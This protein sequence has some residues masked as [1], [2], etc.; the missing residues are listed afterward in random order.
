[1]SISPTSLVPALRPLHVQA[2]GAWIV[3]AAV[4]LG[5][6]SAV[7][8]PGT[9]RDFALD[10]SEWNGLQEL[11][12]LASEQG[13]RLERGDTLDYDA[14]DPSSPLIL[15]HPTQPLD[16]SSLQDF[17]A[18]GGRVLIADDFGSSETLLTE[19]SEPIQRVGEIPEEAA[20]DHL[21]ANPNLPVLVTPGRHAL[22]ENDVEILIANHP[23]G[24]LSAL[25]AVVY[26]ADGELGFVYD[27]TIGDGKLLVVGDSSIFINL[28]LPLADNRQFASNALGYLCESSTSPCTVSVFVGEF[29][30]SGTYGDET[31]TRPGV[32]LQENLEKLNEY[33]RQLDDFV[34]E[35]RLL[36]VMTLLLLLGLVLFGLTVFPFQPAR[37]LGIRFR[38]PQRLLPA[39]EFERNLQDFG[40]GHV[41]NHAL[42]VAI[43]RDEFERLFL[44]AL[45]DG[46][47]EEV[48]DREARYRPYKVK[49][50][51]ERFADRTSDGDET[52]W[53][54]RQRQ[55][56]QIMKSFAR[57]PARSQI[58]INP[59]PRWNA[60]ELRQLHRDCLDALS[61]LGLLEDYEQRTRR[62]R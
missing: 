6:S 61:A 59:G 48:P 32:E 16:A 36:R 39:S 45:Y 60:K 52:R 17:V 5:T 55:A 49:E 3:L 13:V 8:A 53:R 18:D 1:L 11:K 57:V 40:S 46:E 33:V 10:S 30:T 29:E 41:T 22:L 2:F 9:A 38:P 50:T 62:S 43:L 44:P 42:P 21:N 25:P 47:N 31:E 12:H 15:I 20:V 19:F 51:A 14:L 4:L 23:T 54:T 35:R 56:T 24:F 37:F 27:L 7:A 34:P 28:M 58:F 26:Y